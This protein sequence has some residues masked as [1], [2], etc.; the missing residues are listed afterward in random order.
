VIVALSI[1]V[2]L[3]WKRQRPRARLPARP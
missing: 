1:L 2:D 3:V